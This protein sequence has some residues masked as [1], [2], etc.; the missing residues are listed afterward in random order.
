MAGDLTATQQRIYDMLCDGLP[1]SRKEIHTCL[2]DELSQITA[3][4]AHITM[5]RKKLPPGQAIL[6]EVK[7]RSVHYRLVRLLNSPYDGS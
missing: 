2:P 1:H 5:L 7:S 6:V 4:Q 3:I